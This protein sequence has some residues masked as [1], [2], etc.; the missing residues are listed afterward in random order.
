MHKQE[1]LYGHTTR[2]SSRSAAST[3]WTRAGLRY[4][5]VKRTHITNQMKRVQRG[6]CAA[7]TCCRATL[8]DLPD[9]PQCGLRLLEPSRSPLYTQA[10]SC[11]KRTHAANQMK[12]V[13][14]VED[15]L[16]QVWG[17]AAPNGLPAENA[18]KPIWSRKN[19][20]PPRRRLRSP[21]P[22]FSAFPRPFVLRRDRR[23]ETLKPEVNSQSPITVRPLRTY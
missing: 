19:A 21:F 5:R 6:R 20:L 13:Q 7:S 14:R 10:P 23:K 18:A 12:R 17:R 3:Y 1:R 9:Q 2:P 8:H 16:A 22:P 4:T 11:V 15:S